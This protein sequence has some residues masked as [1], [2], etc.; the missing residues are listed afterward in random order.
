LSDS[1]SWTWAVTELATMAAL[2]VIL[3]DFTRSPGFSAG[4]VYAV[5]AYVYDYLE[6]LEHVPTLMNN[7]CG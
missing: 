7:L 5:L 2:V 3:V 6:G 4:A 1:E